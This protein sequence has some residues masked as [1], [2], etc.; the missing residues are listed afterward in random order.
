MVPIWKE[1]SEPAKK[2]D[3]M[4]MLHPEEPIKYYKSKMVPIWKREAE[5]AKKEDDIEM[6]HPNEPVKYY[7]SKMV[8]I[9]KREAEPAKNNDEIVKE[10]NDEYY[11]QNKIRPIWNEKNELD[12]IAANL[13]IKDPVKE[14]KPKV[15]SL[16]NHN[17]IEYVPVHKNKKFNI[18]SMNEF[19]YSPIKKAKPQMIEKFSD[20]QLLY[21]N[22]STLY[23]KNK[24]KPIWN[25]E[26]E[27][28]NS[29]IKLSFE[30]P[31]KKLK[32]KKR[33]VMEEQKN[34]N[35]ELLQP[36]DQYYYRYKIRPIWNDNN[37]LSS[38]QFN[39]LAK[40][41]K[42]KARNADFTDKIKK[43]QVDEIEVLNPEDPISYYKNKMVPIWND[44][45]EKDSVDTNT[46]EE[47]TK[48]YYYQYKIR[49]IWNSTNKEAI[50]SESLS[51]QDPTA[52]KI[53]RPNRASTLQIESKTKK[54]EEPPCTED[55]CYCHCHTVY[56]SKSIP[57]VNPHKSS[58][59][60]VIFNDEDRYSVEPEQDQNLKR[61]IIVKVTKIRNSEEEEEEKDIDIFSGMGSKKKPKLD[62][63]FNNLKT[64]SIKSKS[65]D[66]IIK[67]DEPIYDPS[68]E[69]QT[70]VLKSSKPK[71]GLSNRNKG[72]IYSSIEY[73]YE[74]PR[75][76]VPIDHSIYTPSAPI[77]NAQDLLRKS[78]MKKKDNL[79]LR[80]D[81]DDK[82]AFV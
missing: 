44:E 54:K 52:E 47:P 33:P 67:E 15:L 48:S 75:S 40:P 45:N 20:I 11:Y 62:K 71:G 4:E 59:D 6:L 78:V 43:E 56:K 36:Y 35:F 8:P 31:Q 38:S 29:E 72:A 66:V 46:I 3:D 51:Y 39:V 53:L 73:N 57:P 60:E 10:P 17:E 32:S 70:H 2:E 63:L 7:K 26:N 80:E 69:A 77:K 61:N 74:Q 27:L 12:T 21:P 81:N 79:L 68:N 16:D 22:N 49:P 82:N 18:D 5:P 30:A 76:S 13:S 64:S 23:Y 34:N 1:E 50:T 37:D 42:K 41:T 28:T 25:N 14:E 65:K 24:I 19:E 9:W 58:D 55:H